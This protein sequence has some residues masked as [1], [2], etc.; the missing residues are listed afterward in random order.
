MEE[1]QHEGG[2][3]ASSGTLG[4]T[5]LKKCETRSH[6]MQGEIQL[7]TGGYLT[8]YWGCHCVSLS[9][10]IREGSRFIWL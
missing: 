2:V 5:D 6:H 9:R 3:V 8:V 7:T 4:V 10:G 1:G